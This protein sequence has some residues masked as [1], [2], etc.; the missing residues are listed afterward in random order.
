MSCSVDAEPDR[1]VVEEPPAEDS[2]KAQGASVAASI[3]SLT[4]TIIGAGERCHAIY[5]TIPLPNITFRLSLAYTLRAMH[6][7]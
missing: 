1:V 2:G 5:R 3:F 7:Q 4:N 6:R